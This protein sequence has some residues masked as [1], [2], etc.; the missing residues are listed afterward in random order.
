LRLLPLHHL[1]LAAAV[2]VALAAAS[3]VVLAVALAAE[4][5]VTVEALD[6]EAEEAPLA[7]V[8]TEDLQL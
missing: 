3:A 7:W 5:V 8:L 2:A 1:L 4:I 6:W